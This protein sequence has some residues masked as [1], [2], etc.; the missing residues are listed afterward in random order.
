RSGGQRPSGDGGARGRHGGAPAGAA[1]LIRRFP[2]CVMGRYGHRTFCR[3]RIGMP[4]PPLSLDK[5]RA[6]VADG[7][8]DTVV[9]AITDMQGR[10][11]GKRVDAQFFLDEV[12]EHGTDGCNYLMAVDVDMNTVEGYAISSWEQGYGDLVMTPDFGTLRPI[13]WQ[14]GTALVL[15]DVGWTD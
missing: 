11:Q 15:A 13:P 14:P 6:Q 7:T 3:E 10:L 12:A 4:E 9:V 8:I 5:L 2:S 1:G